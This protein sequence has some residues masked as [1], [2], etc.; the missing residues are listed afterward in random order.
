MRQRAAKRTVDVVVAG[1]LLAITSPLLAAVAVAIRATSPGPALF[2]QRRIG[3]AGEPFTL[4]KFRSMAAD[5]DDAAHRALVLAEL[6]GEDPGTSDGRYKLEGD[7]RITAVGAWLRRTSVDE[8]PQL[9]NVVRGEM[10]LVGPRPL[11]DWEHDLLPADLTEVRARV[12]PGL[13]GRWQ[14]S[15]RNDMTNL[16][17]LEL[18]R[19]YVD[20]LARRGLGSDLAILAATPAALLGGAR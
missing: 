11:I 7:P 1:S 18:D 2:R 10:S 3:L 8:L 5:N 12:R 13:T 9:W 16:E 19:L 14:V 6:A 4:L 20:D 15:G 17:M